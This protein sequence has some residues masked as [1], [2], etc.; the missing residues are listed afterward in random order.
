MKV[1]NSY[2]IADHEIGFLFK[3][4]RLNRIFEPGFKVA[5]SIIREAKLEIHDVSKEIQDMYLMKLLWKEHHK[6]LSQYLGYTETS[7]HQAALIYHDDRLVNFIGPSSFYLWWRAL[8]EVTIVPINVMQEYTIDADLLAALRS[9]KGTD[10][11]KEL[12][13][14]IRFEY[15]EPKQV[16][17]LSVDGKFQKKLTPGKYAFWQY[18]RSIKIINLD[19]RIQSIELKDQE[20][21]TVD[22]VSLSLD[23]WGNYKIQDPEK[24]AFELADYREF[25]QLELQSQLRRFVSQSTLDQVLLQQDALN[26]TICKNLKDQ[27]SQ[28]G[29]ELIKVGIKKLGLPDSVK[30]IMNQVVEAQKRAQ[31]NEFKRDDQET[32]LRSLKRIAK[33][34]E[35]NPL[36][37]RLKE[38]EAMDQVSRKINSISVTGGLEGVIKDLVK[39]N[40]SDQKV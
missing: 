12:D 16:G 23:L 35:N 36:L 20:L 21:I 28:Y 6:K 22:G 8:H 24:A 14:G 15:I 11:S 39:L 27:F 40:P 25:I 13:R 10:V 26:T 4:S 34:M 3:N 30:A 9:L 29:I 37:L 2:T 38:L 31:A 17:L 5:T 1:I 33:E 32:A 18:I 19:L 7:N